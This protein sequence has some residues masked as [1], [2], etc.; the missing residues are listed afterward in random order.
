MQ[1]P[2]PEQQ[3]IL[4]LP[5]GPNRFGVSSRLDGAP[6]A[7]DADLQTVIGFVREASAISACIP[8]KQ[9]HD[10]LFHEL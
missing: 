4:L 8:S 3:S 1:R 9:A 7:P 6:H 10:R 5:S 2:R